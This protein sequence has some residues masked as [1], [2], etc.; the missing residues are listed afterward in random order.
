VSQSNDADTHAVA[1]NL[2]ATQQWIG[3][4]QSALTG[5]GVAA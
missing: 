4:L 1:G 2:D 3:Q 5:K